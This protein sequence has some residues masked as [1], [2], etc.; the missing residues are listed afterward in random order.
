MPPVLG[1]S[2]WSLHRTIGIWHPN[3][4]ADDAV[5]RT[6]PRWG[7]GTMP[8]PA[9]PARARREGYT[10]MHICHF[11]LLNREGG[12]LDEVR[13]ALADAAVRLDMLL[14]DDG[15][16]TDPAHRERDFAWIAR[17]IEAGARLGARRVR[18]VAGK[19]PPSEETL[20]L[21]IDGLARLAKVA[22][23]NGVRLVTENWHE[24][25]RG[26]DEVN[27]VLDSLGDAVGFLVDFGNWKAPE[28]YP[29]LAAVMHRAEDSHAKAQF[30][31]GFA[32]DAVDFGRSVDLAAAAGFAGPFTLI[33][34]GPDDDEWRALAIERDFVRGRLAL[35]ER[36]I[37]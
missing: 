6:E 5:G 33:Y 16:I 28:K 26:P 36:Q 9:I 7:K 20:A 8:L 3:G 25:L 10:G 27:R 14:I 22:A 17:W 4:P 19:R 37:A 11:H 34:D 31:A 35:A 32:L 2:T 1:V 29:G 24:T 21:S 30:G 18:A 13:A 15:D 23:A 12:Y